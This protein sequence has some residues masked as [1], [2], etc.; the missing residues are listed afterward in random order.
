MLAGKSYCFSE[1]GIRK[2]SMKIAEYILC[3]KETTG[4]YCVA[5]QFFEAVTSSTI[6]QTERQMHLIKRGL[7]S[8]AL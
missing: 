5:C 1:C 3:W 8:Q 2:S 7:E 6:A 4:C